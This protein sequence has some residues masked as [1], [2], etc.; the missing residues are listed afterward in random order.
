MMMGLLHGR[1]THTYISNRLSQEPH[2]HCLE[3][4]IVFSKRTNGYEL[5]MASETAGSLLACFDLVILCMFDVGENSGDIM[6]L[7]EWHKDHVSALMPP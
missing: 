1:S 6:H 5:E 3:W 7:T 4:I 2:Q